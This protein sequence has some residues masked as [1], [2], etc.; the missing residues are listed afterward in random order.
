MLVVCTVEDGKEM[1]V[2][3]KDLKADGGIEEIQK[4]IKSAGYDAR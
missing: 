1:L 3:I 2:H 4:A